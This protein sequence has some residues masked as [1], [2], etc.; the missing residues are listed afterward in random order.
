[1][2]N[3]EADR[4]KYM[5]KPLDELLNQVLAKKM[6]EFQLESIKF[7]IKNHGR[8]IIGDEMGVGKTV[9]ALAC[10][11]V[12]KADW[13]VMVVCPASLKYNWY[14]EIAKWLGPKVAKTQFQGTNLLHECAANLIIQC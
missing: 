2:I 12:F 6:Y 14:Q 13:P 10:C 5:Q 3:Y 8:I 11:T 7:A 1:M 4:E 9:Q